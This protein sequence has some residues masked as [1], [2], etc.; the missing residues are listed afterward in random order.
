MATPAVAGLI[1]C[2]VRML[3]QY[4]KKENPD[5]DFVKGVLKEM[6]G[7]N[8]PDEKIIFPSK[9]LKEYSFKPIKKK[10]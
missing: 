6:I 5:F 10:L 4:M 7:Q 2:I 9:Y 3:P 8:N 1:A